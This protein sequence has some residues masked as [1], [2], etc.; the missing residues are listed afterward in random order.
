MTETD[1]AFVP[2]RDA[3]ITIQ[4]QLVEWLRNHA[5][6]LWDRHGVDRASGGYFENISVGGSER[7]PET[8]GN[9]RRGRVGA[10]QLYAFD[11]GRR[12]GWRS[13]SADTVGRGRV[14][15]LTCRDTGQ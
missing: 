10:R 14:Q 9:V 13:A 1:E 8:S 11:A 7:E 15:S 6:P 3:V 2:S 12:L 4:N 5:L